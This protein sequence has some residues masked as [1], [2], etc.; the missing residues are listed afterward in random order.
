MLSGFSW[1]PNKRVAEEEIKEK[2]ERKR[3]L[4]TEL[5][6]CKG[7]RERAKEKSWGVGSHFDISTAHLWTPFSIAN[8][9]QNTPGSMVLCVRAC[10]FYFFIL[11]FF[12]SI[13]WKLET[14]FQSPLLLFVFLVD[15]TNSIQFNLIQY[16]LTDRDRESNRNNRK[17]VEPN[18]GEPQIS[19]LTSTYPV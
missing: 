16:I 4:M 1:N 8:N 11:L 7:R 6:S 12:I 14:N 15:G 17:E 13:G 10:F 9:Y 5:W 2:G 18:A 19:F 3:N